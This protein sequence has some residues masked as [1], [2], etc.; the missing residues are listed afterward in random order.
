MIEKE[1]SIKLLLQEFDEVQLLINSK[2]YK[3][4]SFRTLNNFITNIGKL[5]NDDY[6]FVYTKLNEYLRIIRN[7]SIPLTPNETYELYSLYLKPLVPY[8]EK[9]G[10]K[11][12]IGWRNIA[13][14]ALPINILL[15]I[16]QSDFIFYLIV[17]CV[18]LIFKFRSNYF[19][20]KKLCYGPFY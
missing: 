8:Y 3:R 9:L 5:K 20:R 15:F 1:N 14:F 10:F 19:S 4:Y 18:L 12:F 16:L 17:N 6:D 11:I 2:E 7:N 13:V